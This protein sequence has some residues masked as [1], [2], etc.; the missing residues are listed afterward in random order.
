MALILVADDDNL[1]GDII[2][3]TLRPRGHVVG[4]VANGAD[5]V[6]VVETKRP[7]LVILDCSMPGLG[8]ID[9]LRRI[10]NSPTAFATPV[11]MLTARRSL[12]DEEIALRAGANEYLRKPFDPTE[13]LV[14]A[15]A[16]LNKS[17]LAAAR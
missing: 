14:L 16:L 4:V 6:R 5:A 3:Y 9:A 17:A 13:L 11:L 1:V 8:G 12:Q 7:D 2:R 10:R 15:E